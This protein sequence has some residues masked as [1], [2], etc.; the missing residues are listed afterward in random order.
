MDTC[1]PPAIRLINLISKR[2]TYNRSSTIDELSTWV[3]QNK[4][5][6][7]RSTASFFIVTYSDPFGHLSKLHFSLPTFIPRCLAYACR[8]SVLQLPLS[9]HQ[10]FRSEVPGSFDSNQ[11]KCMCSQSR[12]RLKLPSERLSNE[13]RVP[14]LR[15]LP[16]EIMFS[17]FT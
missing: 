14:C 10:L 9:Q 13:I 12:P 16:A 17:V 3:E 11:T 6:M 8:V 1:I 7:L 2:F 4:D 5:L 15:G